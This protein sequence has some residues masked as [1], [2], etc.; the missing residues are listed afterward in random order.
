MKILVATS[1]PVPAKEKANYVVNIAKRLKAELIVL[2]IIQDEEAAIKGEETLKI[3]YKT[4]EKAKVR[5]TQLLKKGDIVSA[6]ME[7]V[8][9]ES[10]D[11][12]IMGASLGNVVSEWL[13]A[14]VLSKTTTPVVVIPHVFNKA[15]LLRDKK[16]I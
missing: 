7:T 14:D 1:G 5:V 11:L 10:V 4:G 3:F 6:I 13:S 16:N 12:I 15:S 8:E 9:K 2:H